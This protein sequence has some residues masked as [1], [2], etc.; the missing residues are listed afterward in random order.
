MKNG[1]EAL[2]LSSRY[3]SNSYEQKNA[4]PAWISLLFHEHFKSYS[5]L[6]EELDFIFGIFVSQSLM[7]LGVSEI[8]LPPDDE[9][10]VLRDNLL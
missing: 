6:R 7:Q 4:S 2:K 10:L 9:R 1:V 3:L 5:I 8:Y